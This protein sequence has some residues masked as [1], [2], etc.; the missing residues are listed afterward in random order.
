M[1]SSSPP[2][3]ITTDERA[4]LVARVVFLFVLVGMYAITF[5]DA[6]PMPMQL[7]GQTLYLVSL[8]LLSLG[9]LGVFA[10]VF[11]WGVRV[12]RAMLWVLLPDLVALSMFVYLGME[13]DAFYP[14]CILLPV[15]YALVV[16]KR[17][18]WMVGA[19]TAVAY[20]AAHAVYP[21]FTFDSYAVFVFKALVIPLVGAMVAGA[22]T[23]QHEQ[24]AEIEA[25]LLENAEVNERLG[26]RVAELQAVSE[27]TEVIHSSLDFDSVGPVVLDIVAKLIDIES[28]TLFIIDRQESETIFSASVGTSNH[29]ALHEQLDAMA[30]FE[31]PDDHFTCAS[32]FD[33]GEIMVLFCATA[34]DLARLSSEDSLIVS[35]VASELVVAVENSRL[36]KLTK[37]LSITDDLTGLFNY[38]HLQHRL[39]EEVGRSRRY[40]KHLSLL[41]I[42]VDD[43]KNFNDSHGHLAGD[44]ALA[45]LAMVMRQAVREVDLVARYG[46]EEFSVLLP[47]TD[48]AG[49]YSVA[50]KI[51]EAVALF[52]FADP[53]GERC[54]RLT[55]SI[56]LA[57]LPSHA[58]DKESLLREADAALYAAKFGGKNRVRSSQTH[59]PQQQPMAL[60]P[61]EQFD[62]TEPTEPTEPAQP[63]EP[64][65]PT[66]P[67][68]PTGD[69]S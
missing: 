44:M 55:V 56:G 24:A 60:D 69:D 66:V 21:H 62:A 63:F 1:A 57:T 4:Y 8:S 45:D 39:D 30:E 27:I 19:A 9:T 12:Q 17:E 50:E 7:L 16:R 32:V 67:T 61:F 22:V 59:L 68:E 65:E 31:V 49:A 23:K 40:G 53:D 42:D 58:D 25:A 37:R 2:Q 43:F 36:Y 35:A 47:E 11:W 3:A 48:A 28:C 26:R 33:R 29:P 54:C 5:A 20:I 6:K 52:A 13:T 15:M 38:R 51:R 64:T 10:A 18:A 46:G 14:I 41:M 34:E